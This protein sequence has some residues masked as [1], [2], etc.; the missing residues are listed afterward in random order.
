MI[1]ARYYL[2][3]SNAFRVIQLRTASMAIRAR[4]FV[5]CDNFIARLEDDPVRFY[6][7]HLVTVY[8]SKLRD[9]SVFI[10]SDAAASARACFCVKIHAKMSPCVCVC[11]HVC[12]PLEAKYT[13]A[14]ASSQVGQSKKRYV[15]NFH[16][17]ETALAVAISAGTHKRR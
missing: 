12:V 14:R 13:C 10:K 9:R 6:L 7:S 5:A 2:V 15:A 16:F 17:R 1:I 4:L 11:V 3:L 8:P